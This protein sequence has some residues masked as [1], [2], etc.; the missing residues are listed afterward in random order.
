M[1]IKFRAH[2]NGDLWCAEAEGQ[3]IYAIGDSIVEL[4]NNVDVAARL[5]FSGRMAPGEE[6]HIMVANDAGAVV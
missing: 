2:F 4:M 3:D 6:L 5:H 1:F